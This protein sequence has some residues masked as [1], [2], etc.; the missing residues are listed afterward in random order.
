MY[1]VILGNPRKRYM[2]QAA[3]AITV[4][5]GRVGNGSL[6]RSCPSPCF[7]DM[8]SRYVFKLALSPD[9]TGLAAACQLNAAQPGACDQAGLNCRESFYPARSSGQ[10]IRL[11]RCTRFRTQVRA[12]VI[13]LGWFTS[14]IGSIVL[15]IQDRESHSQS[16]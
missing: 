15:Q 9:G 3:T 6:C 8:M 10:V 5:L 1:T 7:S 12:A 4:D 2:N 16:G 13:F 11:V 14:T